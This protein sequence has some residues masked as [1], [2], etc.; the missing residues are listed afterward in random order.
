VTLALARAVGISRKE[1][2]ETQE[3]IDK[4]SR[5]G[6]E[7]WIFLQKGTKGTG[8][9]HCNRLGLCATFQREH[10]HNSQSHDG[11]EHFELR[12]IAAGHGLGNYTVYAGEKPGSEGWW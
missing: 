5:K 10:R 1:R 3:K 9:P 4:E 2:K 8:V 11:Y 6:R 7:P 12:F